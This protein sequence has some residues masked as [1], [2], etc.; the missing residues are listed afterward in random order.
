[1]HEKGRKLRPIIR[2]KKKSIG[3]YPQ[4]AEMME[5]TD[6]DVKIS[7]KICSMCSRRKRNTS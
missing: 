2:R 1:M 7:I 6:R 3:S 4:V 5:F